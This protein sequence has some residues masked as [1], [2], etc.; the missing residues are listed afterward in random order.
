MPQ[1]DTLEKFQN[2]QKQFYLV[3]LIYCSKIEN[4]R[5]FR[6]VNFKE[7]LLFE[8]VG[9]FRG[10]R[11]FD[12]GPYTEIENSE[13]SEIFSRLL[14]LNE[15]LLFE[16]IGN[17]RGFRVFDF[18]PYPEIENSENLEIPKFLKENKSFEIYVLKRFPRFQKPQNFLTSSNKTHSMKFASFGNISL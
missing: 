17:F 9:N 6:V 13:N 16:G 2:I 14:N 15:F 8:D 1:Q 3:S 12:F 18:G 7:F 5:G 10:F 11:L 4:F